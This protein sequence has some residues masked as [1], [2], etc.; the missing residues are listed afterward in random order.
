MEPAEC[1]TCGALV[2][3]VFH[4]PDGQ[5]CG[6]GNTAQSSKPHLHY[7]CRCLSDWIEE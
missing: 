3:P 4:E 2:T 1:P 5:W 7:L 6:W